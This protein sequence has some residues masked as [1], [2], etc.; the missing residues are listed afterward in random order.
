M[1]FEY[2]A[3]I[4]FDD[5]NYALV[6]EADKPNL[7]ALIPDGQ[8][9]IGPVKIPGA[10]ENVLLIMDLKKPA[11][12]GAGEPQ[13][14]FRAFKILAP[15]VVAM[16]GG[17]VS[18]AKAVPIPQNMGA[19]FASS[20]QILLSG[21]VFY[22]KQ[23][24]VDNMGQRWINSIL[25]VAMAETKPGEPEVDMTAEILKKATGAVIDDDEEGEDEK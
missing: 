2:P 16:L 7:A 20:L 1:S 12:A 8:P 23:V 3:K 21:A 4:T 6:A 5:E 24:P 19:I 22:E 13:R 14:S 11:T 9:H 17:S 25:G 10:G 18:Q 15:A